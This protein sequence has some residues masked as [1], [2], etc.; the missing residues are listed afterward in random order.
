MDSLIF[1]ICRKNMLFCVKGFWGVF[2]KL[3]GGEN[4]GCEKTWPD[5]TVVRA[6]E[7]QTGG[8]F[9]AAKKGRSDDEVV[10]S[11]FKVEQRNCVSYLQMT[12]T[13]F[14]RP[15]APLAKG[16]KTNRFLLPRRKK[17][18]VSF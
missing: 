17:Q 14:R 18:A 2:W 11:P 12:K 7:T 6:A 15:F 5:K 9:I 16:G 3:H 8:S 13:A 4:G 1:P 10:S